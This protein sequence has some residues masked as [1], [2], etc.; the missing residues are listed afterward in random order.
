MAPTP[1]YSSAMSRRALLVVLGLCVWCGPVVERIELNI[2][3][4]DGDCSDFFD[5][6]TKITVEAIANNGACKEVH[7]CLAGDDVENIADFE[8]RIR[9]GVPEGGLV[10][11]IDLDRTERLAVNGRDQGCYPTDPAIT[12]PARD[13]TPVICSETNLELRQDGILELELTSVGC[14]EV[15]E[16]CDP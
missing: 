8:A 12:D 14:S 11:E 16:L 15:Y 13:N 4:M 3:D 2:T 7:K 5:S 10:I 9:D 6:I 1:E